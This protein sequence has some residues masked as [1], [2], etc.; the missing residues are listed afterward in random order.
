MMLLHLDKLKIGSRGSELA[1]AQARLFSNALLKLCPA[2]DIEIVSMLTT[3]DKR[4]SEAQKPRD[5]RDWIYE[6]EKAVV[7]RELDC[8]IHSGKDI[9]RE[10]DEATELFA[11]L[12]R[13]NPL[14]ALVLNKDRLQ[15]QNLGREIKPLD[16][17]KQQAVVGTGSLRRRAQLLRARPDLTVLPL[18]GNVPTRI[19]KMQ[20]N[21]Q[22]D[23]VIL[24]AAGMRRL[25]LEGQI[26]HLISADD[27]LPSVNQGILAVQC[28]RD[29]SA[30]ISLLQLLVRT[31]VKPVFEAERAFISVLGAD[32]GSA[33]GVFA[34][35]QG[36]NLSIKGRILA[37]DGSKCLEKSSDGQ[38]GQAQELGKSLAEDLLKQGAAELL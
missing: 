19:R 21:S 22:M 9:P 30:I 2:L 25:A 14:D 33:V 15:P 35:T 12:E 20:E 4:S 36:S 37:A 5:K 23:G 27:M 17:L 29:S 32:C 28:R 3:G 34:V 13:E 18:S 16:F 1:M 7:A 26:S 6:L 10:I 31:E 38:V 24:A 8:A 11:V